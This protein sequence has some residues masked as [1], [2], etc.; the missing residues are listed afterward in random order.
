MHSIV[1]SLTAAL[2]ATN[3]QAQTPPD[4]GALQQQIERERAAPAVVKPV[5]GMLIS[6][7]KF[8]F[9][10]NTLIAADQLAPVVRAYLPAQVIKDGVITLQIIEA[11]FGGTQLE[12]KAKRV[13]EKQI[14]RR[15][16]AQRTK[17]RL[18]NTDALDRAMLLA[19]DL[20]G[21]GGAGALSQGKEDG[22]TDIKRRFLCVYRC[23]LPKNF[24]LSA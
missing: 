17:G 22:E 21:V 9:A 19:D 20:L 11:V 3:A 10:G 14:L 13:S 16:E 12:G 2:I 6:V 18:L 23:T 24:M 1:I 15:V 7:K 5:S 8:N 4:A